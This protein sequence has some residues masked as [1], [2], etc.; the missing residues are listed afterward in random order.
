MKTSDLIKLSFFNLF[1]H[2][3]R[4]FLTSL[5]IIF[6]VGSVIAMLA[7]SEGAQRKALDQIE[8]MGIDN[9]II[10]VKEPRSVGR[11]SSDKANQSSVKQFGL[12]K[13]DLVHLNTFQNIKNINV[14][15]NTR[16]KVYRG[17]KEID[18]K[19]LAV[20]SSFKSS[21][22]ARVDKGRWISKIDEQNGVT[23]CVIGK[24]VARQIFN[25]QESKV[26]GKRIKVSAAVF[27]VIGIMDTFSMDTIPEI[28]RLDDAIFI[29]ESVASTVYGNSTAEPT[30]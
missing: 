8:A 5:G 13:A 18:V 21:V 28:G 15:K 17:D 7:I 3:M 12:T 6:G 1:R 29:P 22:K 23:V 30:G 27:E 19:V 10:Y 24:Q 9:I 11:G 2:K 20:S 4:S 16:H 25:F 26:I 14:M